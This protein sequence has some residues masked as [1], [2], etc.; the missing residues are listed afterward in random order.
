MAASPSALSAPRPDGGSA[1]YVKPPTKDARSLPA[2]YVGTKLLRITAKDAKGS[3]RDVDK[4]YYQLTAV[5]GLLRASARR[6]QI[7]TGPR[8]Q[9]P[10]MYLESL[11]IRRG[12]TGRTLRAKLLDRCLYARALGPLS[13]RDSASPRSTRPTNLA[14]TSSS[15]LACVS[16]KSSRRPELRFARDSLNSPCLPG[17]E[18]LRSRSSRSASL[19]TWSPVS[20]PGLSSAR[21]GDGNVALNGRALVAAN[22]STL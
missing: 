2:E 16:Y 7:C 10:A 5:A 9:P 3:K 18:P 12:E 21:A 22:L 11:S 6:H 14:A 8:E 20:L 1:W 17:F 15:I 19:R 4:A 13:F